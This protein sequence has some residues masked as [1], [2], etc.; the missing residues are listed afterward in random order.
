MMIEK[1]K[2][3]E[4]M[5]KDTIDPIDRVEMRQK[6]DGITT[7]KELFELCVE[8]SEPDDWDGIFTPFQRWKKTVVEE[9]ML[10]RIQDQ[11]D[12]IQNL[13]D[14]VQEAQGRIEKLEFQLECT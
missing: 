11:N 3:R 6:L 10:K 8:V 2:K 14:E 5:R 7:L 4:T 1:N 13:R 9:E 12:T